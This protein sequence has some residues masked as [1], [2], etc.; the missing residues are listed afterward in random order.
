MIGSRRVNALCLALIGLLVLCSSASA[1][2]VYVANSGSGTVSVINSSTNAVV[3]AVAIGKEPVDVA[4]TPDGRYA[5][6]VDGSGNSVYVIDTKTRA[7]V[8]GPI[9]VGKAPRGIAITP[10][11]G[12]AYVTNSGDDTVTVL[13]TATFGPVGEPIPVGKEPDGVAIST[14]GGTAFVAQ[15]GGEI[16]VIDTNRAEVVGTIDDSFGPS[17]ITMT[18]DGR[19]GFVTNHAADTVT[20]FSPASHTVIGTPISVGEEP[21]GIATLPDGSSVY[22]ASAVSGSLTQIDPSIDMPVGAPIE[23]P[24]ATG[25][26]FTPDG[27]HGYV[28]DGGGS[29][30]SLLDPK[31][32]TAAG[33]ITVG[34]KPVAVAVVPDQ[35]PTASFWVSPTSRRAKKRL[36]FHASNS[37]DPDGAIVDYSWDFGDHGRA[38]GPEPTRAHSYQRPGTYFVTLKVTDNEGCATETVFTGQTVSC[39]GNPLASITVP[40]K[41]LNEAGPKLQIA[42]RDRQ[43]MQKLVVRAR[44]PQVACSLRAGGIVVTSTEENGRKIRHTRRLGSAAAPAATRGWRRLVLH[45]PGTTRRAAERAV[46]AG[47]TAKARIAVNARDRTNEVTVLTKVVSL[48]F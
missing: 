45:V 5:W 8:Q 2:D 18:P 23:F 47:G 41:V 32:N 14:D 20:A 36:T 17:R 27:L 31:R 1:R 6:V 42:G 7:V 30:A 40:I 39:K 46:L 44:C 19:R 33:A 4:I 9:A 28:T 12:R 34:E 48:G 35:A 15:R 21:T 16:S 22:A 29:T 43:G 37:I 10:N 11:G 13:N 26:A 24:G 3:A 38:E 25:L